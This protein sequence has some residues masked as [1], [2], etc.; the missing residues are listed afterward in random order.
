[1]LLKHEY[2][3]LYKIMCYSN[4]PVELY[5]TYLD[6]NGYPESVIIINIVNFDN[7]AMVVDIESEGLPEFMDDDLIK[8]S[9]TVFNDNTYIVKGLVEYCAII[10][11]SKCR[12]KIVD[13]SCTLG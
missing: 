6:V 3:E 11:E 12:C 5:F 2:D 1:M 7:N 4:F 13:L 8:V 9:I 10:S